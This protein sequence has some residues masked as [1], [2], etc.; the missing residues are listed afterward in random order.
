MILRT[1][2]L[3]A[4]WVALVFPSVLQAAVPSPAAADDAV[5]LAVEAVPLN[6]ENDMQVRAGALLYRGGIAVRSPD[7]RFGGFSGLAVSPGRAAAYR[8]IR[9]R[10]L[11]PHADSL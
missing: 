11:V 9:P 3:R 4:L 5:P 1:S 8:R 2:I 7:E 10:C 6:P